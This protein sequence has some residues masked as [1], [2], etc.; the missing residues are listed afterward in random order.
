MEHITSAL[1]RLHLR[2]RE[3]QWLRYFTVFT[4]CALAAGFIPSG[5]VKIMGERFTALSSLHPM[6]AYLEALH[7]T[8]FYYTFIGVMQ[9]L[10]AMLLLIPR[11]ATLGAFL[12]FP[13]ILNIFVLTI[14]VRFDGSWLTSPLMVLANIYLLL[15]DYHKFRR[16][17]PLYANKSPVQTVNRRFPFLFFAL[18]FLLFITIAGS[19]VL[20]SR[21][22]MM[23]GNTF[24]ACTPQCADSPD[25]EACI[26]FCDCI[27]KK[28]Q[29]LDKCLEAY[30]RA[31][32]D[33]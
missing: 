15:W 21:F 17:L 27:H 8:G 10:A 1:D 19:A 26:A 13:I 11:T 25:P 18:S 16:I 9:V 32:E 5:M 14:A 29:S 31:L 12:Y 7:H 28:G 3:N 22:S 6:G 2:V 23:P 20:F 4:R 33:K 24:P 30:Q